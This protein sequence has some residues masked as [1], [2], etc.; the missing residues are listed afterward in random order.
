MKVKLVAISLVLAL[1]SMG[2]ASAT[3]WDT[4]DKHQDKDVCKNLEGDQETV[5]DGYQVN[6]DGVCTPIP[7]VT[8]GTVTSVPTTPTPPVTPSS[9]PTPPPVV[10]PDT[11]PATVPGFGGK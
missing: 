4:H 3:T 10:T 5:P 9:T 1:S 8:P 11:T 6:S 7:P 2:V